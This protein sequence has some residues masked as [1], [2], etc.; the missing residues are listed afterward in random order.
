MSQTTDFDQRLLEIY[1]E[2]DRDRLME[3]VVS[4]ARDRLSAGG[5][6]IFL[7]DS[8]TGRYVLRGTTGLLESGKNPADRIVNFL[9]CGLVRL[10][11]ILCPA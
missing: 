3:L 11:D 7:R 2:L 4:Y 6:S 10:E 1:G 8:I 9:Y 5:S